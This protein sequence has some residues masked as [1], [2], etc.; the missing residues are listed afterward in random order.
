MKPLILSLAILAAPA[1]A[2]QHDHG[3][4]QPQQPEGHEAHGAQQPQAETHPGHEAPDS[5]VGHEAQDPHAAHEP[6]PEPHAG[7]DLQDPHAG[8]EMPQDEHAG[9]G[10]TPAPPVAAPP[11][12]AF[13]GPAH[14]ADRIFGDA[15][16]AQAREESS[17]EHGDLKASKFLLERLEARL[18]KEDG[19]LVDAQAWWGGDIDKLWLKSEGEG[20]FDEPIEEVEVQALWS[21]AIDP[22]F[23][24]QLGVRQDFRTGPERTHLV[25]GVQGL[26]PY[27]FEVDGAMFLSHEG[28]LT[29]R[30]EAEY[31]LRITQ[32]LILQ[33][34]VEIDLSAQDVPE[35]GL[36]A[37]LSHAAAGIRLRYEIE[38][39]F[40]PYVGVEFERT[41]GNTTDFTR[42]AG[43]EAGG[44]KFLLGMRAWF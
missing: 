39:E 43:E 25:L 4:H 9:H 31:D 29:A 44:W 36:G 3:Q 42:A 13:S 12:A 20:A 16:M 38:P 30:F 17:R 11:P 34:R 8:H 5:H 7:H 10:S 18:G 23:D 35:L 37:G 26:A 41:F 24:L 28:E 32:P 14:A 22:W 21:H 15:V 2:Q 40:A 33:P 1:A 6:Q 19:W 27:W